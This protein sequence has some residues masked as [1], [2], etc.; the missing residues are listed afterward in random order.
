MTE[1]KDET[2]RLTFAKQEGDFI[3][4]KLVDGRRTVLWRAGIVVIAVAVVGGLIALWRSG[5]PAAIPAETYERYAHW[6]PGAT[7]LAICGA[8]G[9][10]LYLIGALLDVSRYQ[11]MHDEYEKFMTGYG[12]DP[13]G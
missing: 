13:N 6:I 1:I 2:L 5:A 11:G 10:V 12:R 3:R 9:A 4:R 7:V 8:L